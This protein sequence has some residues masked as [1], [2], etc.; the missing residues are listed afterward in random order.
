MPTMK[1]TRRCNV[2]GKPDYE[3][4]L[5]HGLWLCGK[6]C[7]DLYEHVINNY[8]NNGYFHLSGHIPKKIYEKLIF[9][10]RTDNRKEWFIEILRRY[11]SET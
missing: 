2:C 7:S 6:E 1:P 9:M 5:F 11:Y 3:I 8:G 10:Q 4:V